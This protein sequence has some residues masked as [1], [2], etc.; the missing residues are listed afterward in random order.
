[1]SPSESLVVKVTVGVVSVVHE[2][3]TRVAGP[4]EEGVPGVALKAQLVLLSEFVML[5]PE[6]EIAVA[7]VLLESFTSRYEMVRVLWGSIFHCVSVTEDR[8]ERRAPDWPVAVHVPP[9]VCV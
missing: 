3:S 8:N 9:T 5:R 1:M 4:S 2:P 6:T 7:L